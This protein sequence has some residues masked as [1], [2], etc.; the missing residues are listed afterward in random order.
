MQAL[1]AGPGGRLWSAHLDSFLLP[2]GK[3][4]RLT[5]RQG[6]LRLTEAQAEAKKTVDTVK[7]PIETPTT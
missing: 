3:L 7:A 2:D 6:Y 5:D 1:P 4:L